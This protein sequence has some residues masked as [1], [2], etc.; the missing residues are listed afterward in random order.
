MKSHGS[1][2]VERHIANQQ[3]VTVVQITCLY[4]H[5]NAHDKLSS[6]NYNLAY[7]RMRNINP[8]T[9][10]PLGRSHNTG[11][12]Y[13]WVNIM[14]RQPV[15]LTAVSYSPW[16]CAASKLHAYVCTAHREGSHRCG[17]RAGRLLGWQHVMCVVVLA[18]HR[19]CHLQYSKVGL[20]S[21]YN[22]ST[23]AYMS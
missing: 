23:I 7:A 21:C 6:R 15:G 19:H 10:R 1:T 5:H 4:P 20:W 2:F 14:P 18:R 13:R 17:A 22:G 8:G 11:R 9:P 16:S 3:V 12:H